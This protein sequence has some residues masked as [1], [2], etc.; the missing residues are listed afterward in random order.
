MCARCGVDTEE[1]IQVVTECE[2]AWTHRSGGFSWGTLLALLLTGVWVREKRVE[3]EYGKNK[4][5]TLPCC[6]CREGQRTLRS[7]REIKRCLRE[8]PDYNRLFEKF[9]NARL[10]VIKPS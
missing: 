3:K 8:I 4:V 10:T 2:R 7:Q 1:I 6:V 9:P 5:Y